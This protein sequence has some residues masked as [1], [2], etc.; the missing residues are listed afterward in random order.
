MQV[1]ERRRQ[2]DAN[3]NALFEGQS[4]AKKQIALQCAW[5]VPRGIWD[6]STRRLIV[7]QLHHVV[8]TRAIATYV[9][10]VQLAIESARKRLKLENTFEL[11]F[12]WAVVIERITMHDFHCPIGTRDTSRQP[13]FSISPS[14]DATDEFVVWHGRAG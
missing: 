6:L 13:H 2:R 7:S 14:T 11:T 5:Q 9:E 8:K 10:E 3:L 12:K 1:F 4:A